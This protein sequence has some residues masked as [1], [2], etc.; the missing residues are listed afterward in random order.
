MHLVCS[1][2]LV[3]IKLVERPSNQQ[4]HE[5]LA[6]AYA[7]AR[8]GAFG[9]ALID[10]DLWLTAVPE[11]GACSTHAPLA[12]RLLSAATLW[13]SQVACAI[14]APAAHEAAILW[15]AEKPIGTAI[16]QSDTPY[17]AR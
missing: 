11:D 3:R 1:S 6:Q 5:A 13:Q 2:G 15:P 16:F 10:G 4:L 9:L 8:V 17:A 14:E 7:A 12:A